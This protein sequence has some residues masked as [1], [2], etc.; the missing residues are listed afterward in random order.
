MD[1]GFTHVAD[2]HCNAICLVYEYYEYFSLIKAVIIEFFQ[3]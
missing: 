3:V 2:R 1:T